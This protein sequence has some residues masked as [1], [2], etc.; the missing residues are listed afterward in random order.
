MSDFRTLSQS[1]F[2]SPQITIDQI[3][4]AKALGVT[5]VVN[6]RPDG[7]QPG[8]PEGA[9]IAAAAEAAGLTYVAIPVT[10]AG[11]SEPQV[12]AMAKALKEAEGKVLAFC[13][14]GTRSTLLWS[15]AQASSGKD[16][17][18]ISQAAMAAGYDISPVRPA[19][20]M[21]AARSQG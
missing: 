4:E 13:R 11:F 6:N 16:P 3:T 10:S 12:D 15:L 20:D 8:Q 17:N 19:M 21:F 14:S 9:E 5:T 7:E 2:A 1:V 18:A